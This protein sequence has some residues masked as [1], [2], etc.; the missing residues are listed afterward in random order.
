MPLWHLLAYRT[1]G[2]YRLQSLIPSRILKNAARSVHNRKD[3]YYTSSIS[4]GRHLLVKNGYFWLWRRKKYPIPS[5]LRLERQATSR[6][7]RVPRTGK[8]A[9]ANG[10]STWRAILRSGWCRDS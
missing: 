4:L 9:V 6:R 3:Q 7:R 8:H 10:Q 1:L 2:L 5:V